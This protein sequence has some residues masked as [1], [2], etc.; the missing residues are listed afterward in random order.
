MSEQPKPYVGY[1]RKWRPQDFNHLEGQGQVAKALSAEIEKGRIGHAFIFSGPRG[2]GKTSSARIL[3]KAINCLEGPTPVPCG[4]CDHCTSIAN[5]SNLDVIEIDG[6]SNN[7]VD[8]VRDLRDAINHV[9]F[10]CRY[11]VYI[12]DEVHMLSVP[13]FNALLKTLE[14]P[15]SYVVFIFATTEPEKIPD[16]IKS[17]CQVFKFRPIT[18]EDIVHRLNYIIQQERVD[19]EE[20]ERQQILEAIALAAEGGMRDAQV[21]LDQV[22][23]LSPGT[24]RLQDVRD[25]LGVADQN[26]LV[27]VVEHIR[28]RNTPA[29]LDMVREMM[30]RG[31]DLERFV[32]Q[33]LAFLR[34]LLIIRYGGGEDLVRLGSEAYHKA[35]ELTRSM[36]TVVLVNA[37]NVMLDLE[38]RMKQGAS[39]RFLL[40]FALIRLTAL[41]D[42]RS[43]SELV[44]Q[45]ESG[46]GSSPDAGRTPAQ[47]SG[48]APG[49]VSAPASTRNTYQTSAMVNEVRES[50]PAMGMMPLS[51]GG[52]LEPVDPSDIANLRNLFIKT[53]AEK[54]VS[55]GNSLRAVAPLHSIVGNKAYF[56]HPG[57]PIKGYDLKRL[58]KPESRKVIVE[59][60][61]A[62]TGGREFIVSFSPPAQ[63]SAVP[64]NLNNHP[65][66][67]SAP[68]PAP[69][70]VRVETPPEPV[71][72]T[73]EVPASLAA[74]A[75]FEEMMPEAPLEMEVTPTLMPE[76]ADL[77]SESGG[78]DVYSAS[79]EEARRNLAKKGMSAARIRRM[80]QDNETLRAKVELARKIFNGEIFDGEN[81]PVKI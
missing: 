79:I 42:L 20:S 38:A 29:L 23:S 46:G 14:E 45:L 53:V 8:Q 32:K 11:K 2:V 72:E 25:F 15:P 9:P 36:E 7:G 64:S 67:P 31:R 43:V 5:G 28:D 44:R 54:D 47:Q 1:A 78:G 19:I 75:V 60:L 26:S 41:E 76:E 66:A 40:E 63:A 59:T 56:G 22:I 52:A 77:D 30:E 27:H 48:G 57:V 21:A 12:I 49:R 6:A 35:Q 55:L 62:C 10:S 65:A 24:L 3:A 74:P 34:D 71:M 18:I 58:E 13:A 33:L 51:G 68:A 69:E 80:L 81:R 73:E 39:P 4:H 16:T 50:T 37:V 17:R 70:L 61:R